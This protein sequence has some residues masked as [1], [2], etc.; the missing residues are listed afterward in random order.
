M[1][2]KV[3]KTKMLGKIPVLY[4]FCERMHLPQIID[5]IVPEKPWADNSLTIGQLI[6]ALVINR[7]TEPIPFY[8]VIEWIEKTGFSELLHVPA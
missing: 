6:T 3:T 1:T 7:L 8:K 5:E 2:V 4:R